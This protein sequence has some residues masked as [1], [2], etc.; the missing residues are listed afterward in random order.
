MRLSFFYAGKGKEGRVGVWRLYLFE[1]VSQGIGLE[2][3][4]EAEKGFES[5]Q[6]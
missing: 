2:R 5:L 3:F 4:K 6:V 1:V